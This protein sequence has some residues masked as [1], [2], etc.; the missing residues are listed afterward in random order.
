MAYH[1]KR[2]MRS[3]NPPKFCNMYTYC[4]ALHSGRRR[5]RQTSRINENDMQPIVPRLKESPIRVNIFRFQVM[6]DFPPRLKN[7]QPPQSTT[8]VEKISSSPF[9]AEADT[10]A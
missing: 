8:G 6:T 9:D 5:P 1:G 2:D 7:G 10:Q 4:V 3:C